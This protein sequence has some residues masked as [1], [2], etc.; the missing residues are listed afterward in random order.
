MARGSFDQ[1]LRC[2]LVGV[3]TE[4]VGVGVGAGVGEGGVSVQAVST[5]S[6]APAPALMMKLRRVNDISIHCTARPVC[7]LYREQDVHRNP[8]GDSRTDPYSVIRHLSTEQNGE[9]Q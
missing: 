4:L 8:P 9:G 3:G 5:S 6:D 2:R 7:S 1:L